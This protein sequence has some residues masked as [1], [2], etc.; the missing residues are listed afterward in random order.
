MAYWIGIQ[1]LVK[2]AKKTQNHPHVTTTEPEIQ[3][4]N[5]FRFQLEDLL[6]PQ[7]VLTAL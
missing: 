2:V 4:K 3:N 6:N 5:F 1:G 7:S